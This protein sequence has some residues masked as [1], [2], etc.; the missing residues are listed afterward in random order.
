VLLARVAPDSVADLVQDVFLIAMGR[1]QALRDDSAFAPWLA[2]IARR[3]AADWRRRRRE[4]VPLEEVEPEAM[5]EGHEATE[6]S[7]PPERADVESAPRP[8]AYVSEVMG[9][10][11]PEEA[12]AVDDRAG[13]AGAEGDSEDSEEASRPG[14]P[15]V[16]RREDDPFLAELRR[17]ISDDEPLGPREH[18]SEG[19]PGIAVREQVFE[20]APEGRRFGVLRRRR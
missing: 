20:E 9:G 13:D 11:P 1:L 19:E 14:Q 7:E 2:T 10:G 18:E 8:A 5:I 6:P 15:E 4:T 16:R 17:A 12:A 3:R